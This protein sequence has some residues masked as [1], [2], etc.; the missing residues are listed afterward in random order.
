MT[1]YEYE[2]FENE[3]QPEDYLRELFI[4]AMVLLILFVMVGLQSCKAPQ[5]FYDC[6]GAKSTLANVKMYDTIIDSTGIVEVMPQI[7]R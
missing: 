2:D 4:D 1:N 3:S 6:Q 7:K 5:N